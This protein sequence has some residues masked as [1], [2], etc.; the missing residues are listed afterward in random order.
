MKIKIIKQIVWMVACFILNKPKFKAY[1]FKSIIFR[2]LEIE[3]KNFISIGKSV[4]I[5]K[6]ASIFA[7]H[8]NGNPEPEIVIDDFCSLGVSNHIAA[9]R[10]VVF[11]KYVLTAN[12]VYIS[13][14]NHAYEDIDT[15]IMRQPIKFRSEVTIGDGTWIGENVCIIGATIGKN[16]V[17]GANSVVTGSIPDYSVAAGNPARIIKQYNREKSRWERPAAEQNIESPPLVT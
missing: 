6:N 3:G 15:P 5:R 2:P 14:N 7:L 17:I 10:K 1:R 11:G 16:S 13:D 12:N 4:I 9:V 8:S